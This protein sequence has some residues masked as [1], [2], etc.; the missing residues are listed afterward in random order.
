MAEPTEPQEDPSADPAPTAADAGSQPAEPE[1]SGPGRAGS[2]DDAFPPFDPQQP[3]LPAGQDA[4]VRGVDWPSALPF[5]NLF[6]TFRIAKQG[7]MMLLALAT[8][9][10]LY[11]AGQALD[12]IWSLL[13]GDRPLAG[14][15]EL[16]EQAAV[17]PALDYGRTA[18]LLREQVRAE[19]DA[20]RAAIA[21]GRGVELATV[22]LGDVKGDILARRADAVRAARE[23]PADGVAGAREA[24]VRAAYAN[25]SSEWDAARRIEGRGPFMVFLEYEIGQFNAAVAALL[26]LD[27]PGALGRL[28]ALLF[29]GPGWALTQHPVFFGLFAAFALAV[30]AVCGGAMCRIA[31][32]SFAR[33]EMISLREA[34]K[35]SSGKF[36][37]FVS[38]PLIPLIL[39]LA[40][41]LLAAVGGALFNFWSIG[42]VLAAAGF[43]LILLAG[44]VMALL[45]VGLVGGFNLM[46]PTIAVESTDSFDAMSRSFNYLYDKPWRLAFYDAVALVYAAI[47]YAAARLFV[48]LVL[49][50]S[51]AF[52]GLF[53][54]RDLEGGRD[55][56]GAIWT[57][58]VSF[59]SLTYDVDYLALSPGYDLAASVLSFWIYLVVALLAAFALSLY[60]SGSTIIYFLI[61]REVDATELDDVYVEYD[62][63][64]LMRELAVDEA[65]DGSTS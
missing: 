18:G 41:G 35:F 26:T 30:L 46:Y 48:F 56:L 32:V 37:S 22:D 57:E 29:V 25:A 24:A 53:V 17:D 63:A 10:L 44:L 12:G 9:L 2:A 7:S 3:S 60:F 51:H 21:R 65:K 42:A 58:R 5:L 61:R 34:L 43:F 16:N 64:A 6:K 31:A 39:L 52:A 59:S 49:A 1:A 47:V 50:L 40:L 33:D 13:P 4:I 15:V 8:V 27:V 19:Y 54:F 55:V 36:V 20:R 62:E 45:V 28:W 23:L 14:E 11:L 38:A